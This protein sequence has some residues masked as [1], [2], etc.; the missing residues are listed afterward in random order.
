MDITIV[1]GLLIFG[2]GAA[3]GAAITN[4]VLKKK[5]EVILEEELKEVR[6]WRKREAKISQRQIMSGGEGDGYRLNKHGFT[7]DAFTI[8][9]TI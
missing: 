4:K 9:R 6:E 5:Y 8:K 7:S 3:V 1:R 2:C